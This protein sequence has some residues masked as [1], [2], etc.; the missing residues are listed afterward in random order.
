KV[1]A[2]DQSKYV[3]VDGGIGSMLV[4]GGSILIMSVSAVIYMLADVTMQL[5]ILVA[6]IFIVC[7]M[8]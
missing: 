6:P 4:L 5:D 7:Y 2:M 8:F 3:S 1:Y